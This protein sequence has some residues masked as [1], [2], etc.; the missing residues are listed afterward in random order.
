VPK[1]RVEVV[2]EDGDV[3]D[4][5]GII[6]KA[7]HTG[8]IGDGKVWVIPVDTIVRVRTGEKDAAAI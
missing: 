5:V 7:A 8:R 1:V 4:V 2:V 6:A 3:E